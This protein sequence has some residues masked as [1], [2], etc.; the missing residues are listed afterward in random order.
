M[1]LAIEQYNV[2]LLTGSSPWSPNYAQ[3]H[4]L[5][6][7]LCTLSLTYCLCHFIYCVKHLTIDSCIV[8]LWSIV[9]DLLPLVDYTIFGH[10][11]HYWSH[12]TPW[13]LFLGVACL[14]VRHSQAYVASSSS[15]WSCLS[16]VDDLLTIRTCQ[17]SFVF[18][19]CI[20]HI[21]MLLNVNAYAFV[22]VEQN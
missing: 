12:L 16:L 5:C 2:H 7:C 18:F 21:R 14:P 4:L 20:F 9:Q 15:A 17:L 6:C 19:C 13:G 3:L 1:L 10:F 8:L 11:S 22:N